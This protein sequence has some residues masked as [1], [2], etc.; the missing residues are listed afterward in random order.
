MLRSKRPNALVACF[1]RIDAL[2]NLENL[3]RLYSANPNQLVWGLLRTRLVSSQFR[4][5][6]PEHSIDLDRNV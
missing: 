2:L 3:Q 6:I 4:T 5:R 1:G